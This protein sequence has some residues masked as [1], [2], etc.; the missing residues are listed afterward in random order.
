MV[1][2]NLKG[3]IMY[4][5]CVLLMVVFDKYYSNSQN[6]CAPCALWLGFLMG[7]FLVFSHIYRITGKF[8]I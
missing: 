3:I 8:K 1:S 6:N 5:S 4:S 7:I 2:H